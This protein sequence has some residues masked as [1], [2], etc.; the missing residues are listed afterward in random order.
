MLGLPDEAPP[1]EATDDPFA[2]MGPWL[3]DD[4][5]EVFR[6]VDG[7]VSRQEIIALNQLAMDTHW[8]YVKLGYP[9]ST[10]T[11][12]P[13]RDR[14]TQALPYGMA[15]VT[16]QAV[17]NKAWDLTNKTT[18]A[19]LVDFPQVE[20]EP[21][22][23][24]EEARASC[25]Y[26]T[27]F[28]TQNAGEQG[29]NDAVIWNDRVN[30]SLT[31]ASAFLECW[32]DPTGGGYIPLQIPAH[33]QAVSPMSPLVGPDGMPTTAPIMRYVTSVGPDGEP[34]EESKFTDDATHAAPQWQPKLMA[35]R[36]Q[37]EHI[38]V[39]PETKSVEEAEKV[40][41]LGYC[42]LGEA[43]RRWPT[44]AQMNPDELTKLTDWTPTRY[45][46]LLPFFLRG[47]WKLT[48]GRD[49][50]KQGASDERIMFYYHP[51][52][53]ACPDYKKG[54]DVVVTGAFQGRILDKQFLSADVEVPVAPDESVT[55]EGVAPTQAEAPAT[56]KETRCMEIP[57]VQI[58]P[59]QDPDEQ[60]P[61]GRAYIELF[62][63]AVENNAHLAMSAS[64]VI[65]RNLH[66]EGYIS[67]TSPVSGQQREDSRATGELIPLVRAEDRPFWGEKLAFEPAFFSFYELSDEAINSI[68][69]AERAAKGSQQSQER[70]GKAIQ[71][72]T[73]NNN[74]SLGGM[75]HAVNNAYC[76]WNRI[77]TEQG[78]SKFTT[79]QQ[80]NYVGEDGIFKQQSLT[81]VDFAAVGKITIKTGGTLI[82]PDTK[83]Q[84]LAGLVQVGM[85]DKDEATEAGRPLF[86]RKL[87]L[88]ASSHE[89]R[90]ERQITTFNKGVPNAEWVGQWQQYMQQKQAFDAQQMQQQQAAQQQQLEAPLQQAEQQKVADHDRSMQMEGEKHRMALEQKSAEADH[91]IRTTQ[92]TTPP[93]APPP[94]PA[95]EAPDVIVEPPDMTPIA[96]AIDQIG[97]LVQAVLSK[98]PV[99]VAPV[100]PP[101]IH[102]H[103]AQAPE[104]HVAGPTIH[105]A[106]P[107][108]PGVTVQQ[109]KKGK[110]KGKLTDADGKTSTFEIGGDE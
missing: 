68:G 43:K 66:L 102:V 91:A 103:P 6:A 2:G 109:P 48:D 107:P 79:A 98:E 56:K 20:A 33:P 29:T 73:A 28:L 60:N 81:S 21:G 77:K 7:M 51:Y 70:S 100:E 80:I 25:D 22:S 49:K 92:A 39:F 95:P 53:K 106:T 13:G 57:V 75:N 67:S 44:V 101:V 45:F 27:R 94:A 14:Y 54:A 61:R 34:T 88:P 83:I 42:T 8:T 5:Q 65:D 1:E 87:S 69:A 40:I 84:N 104:V 23:D 108:A 64:Q 30:R 47:R 12:E 37:N 85:L 55:P 46:A 50:A 93:P 82:P 36:W 10:L 96:Q 90:I 15:G 99:P 52:V 38:R 4:D 72:A 59:R 41:I 110:R 63:G 105:N 74:V 89:Q 97:I 35:Q 31:C 9:W 16:I 62:A 32:T 19:L 24:T 86:S 26:I 78:M 3:E 17:P 76:R 71:L 18:E 11:K 58:T